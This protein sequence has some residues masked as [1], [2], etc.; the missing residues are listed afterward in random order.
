MIKRCL[1]VDVETSGLN[2]EVDKMTEVGAILYSLT[3]AASLVEFS[4]LTEC[5]RTNPEAE[6]LTGI[7]REMLEE[8]CSVRLLIEQETGCRHLGSMVA[9]LAATAH[10]IVAHNA[11]FDRSWLELDTLGLPWLCTMEDFRFPGVESQI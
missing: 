11:E 3:S 8:S 1:I 7:T 6:R 10:V 5:Q 2:P 9:S 4:S